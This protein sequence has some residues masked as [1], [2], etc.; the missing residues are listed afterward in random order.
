MPKKERNLAELEDAV[1]DY[2]RKR[3]T[4]HDEEKEELPEQKGIGIAIV[5]KPNSWKSTLLNTFVGKQLAKVE[6]KL[7]TTRDYL[8]WEFKSQG[9][10]IPSTI[11]QGLEKKG[12]LTDRKDCLWQ[13]C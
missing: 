7:G 12:K 3:N 1:L 9:N 13:D 10:D 11:L 2:A 6:D 5:G 8:V 4:T